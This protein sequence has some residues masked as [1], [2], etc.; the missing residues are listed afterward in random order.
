MFLSFPEE[1]RWNDERNAV[2]FGVEIGE[3]AGVIRVPYRPLFENQTRGAEPAIR[4]NDRN[5]QTGR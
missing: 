4:L 2:E 1:T 3:Y 5:R